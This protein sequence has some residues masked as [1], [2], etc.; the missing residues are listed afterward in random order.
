ML[1]SVG[2]LDGCVEGLSESVGCCDGI[3]DG[4]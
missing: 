2:R 3:D 1:V 4:L